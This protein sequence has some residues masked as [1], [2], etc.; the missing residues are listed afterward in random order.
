MLSLPMTASLIT[1]IISTTLFIF[2]SSDAFKVKKRLNCTEKG[3]AVLITGHFPSS[4]NSARKIRFTACN[5]IEY[6]V[7]LQIEFVNSRYYFCK[8]GEQVPVCYDP[9]DPNLVIIGEDPN[10]N[11]KLS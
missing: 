7:W 1:L 8:T 3:T 2:Y 10:L 5:G 6:D 11:D 9:E 4:G